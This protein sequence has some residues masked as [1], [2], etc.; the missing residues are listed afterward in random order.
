M[1]RTIMDI[2]APAFSLAARPQTG[3]LGHQGSQAPGRPVLHL[4]SSSRRPRRENGTMSS[5]APVQCSSF[6]CAS[7]PF[8]R[9][10][11]HVVRG[12]RAQGPSRLAVAVASVPSFSVCRP[13][14]DGPEHGAT[15]TQVGTKA[16]LS[17]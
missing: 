3:H 14:L 2:S 6:V 10:G 11:L 12:H 15:L 7:R 5:L 17:S 4:V 8:L 9:P 16:Q 13:R 1:L